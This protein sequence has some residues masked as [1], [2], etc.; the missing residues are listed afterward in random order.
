MR[1]I[2]LAVTLSLAWLF[3]TLVSLPL[4]RSGSA[5]LITEQ[6]K[7]TSTVSVINYRKLPIFTDFT[8]NTPKFI[9]KDRTGNFLVLDSG[10]HRLTIFNQSMKFIRQIGQIGQGP[11]DL[12]TPTDYAIDARGRIYI[13]DGG[14]SRIQVFDR[15]GKRLAMIPVDSKSLVVDVNSRGEILLNQPMKGN[16]ICVYSQEGKL[17]KRFGV[18]M[19]ISHAY[20]GRPNDDKYRIPLSRAQMA[21]DR[22]DN[23]YVCYTF[24]PILQK[25]DASGNLLWEARL[26]GGESEAL[27]KKFWDD[28][29]STFSKSIDGIQMA[30]ICADFA[31]DDTTRHLY[32]LLGDRAIY[33]ANDSGNRLQVAHDVDRG[34]ALT[35]LTAMAGDLYVTDFSGS[36]YKIAFV[37]TGD[38][39]P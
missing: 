7:P 1:L 35:T 17:L 32:V 27:V 22:Q 29:K 19:T 23:V 11:E 37:K 5:P 33:V 4:E 31:I 16:V 3:T 30:I 28:P 18:L 21:I 34:W 13:L 25:Y 39:S 38:R 36:C 6:R 14:N 24:A 20:P 9:R 15:D 10:N 26:A 8:F 2:A 12:F